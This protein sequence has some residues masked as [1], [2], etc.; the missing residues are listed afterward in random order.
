MPIIIHN[1]GMSNKL[2]EIEIKKTYIKELARIILNLYECIIF[3]SR[4]N[5][6]LHFNLISSNQSNSA[7]NGCALSSVLCWNCDKMGLKQQNCLQSR[8][9][10]CFGLNNELKPNSFCKKIEAK[11]DSIAVG[12]LDA[13]YSTSAASTETQ[14]LLQHHSQQTQH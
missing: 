3:N 2:Q 10:F 9:K 11:T 12:K 1:Y 6:R 13:G 5:S 4:N 14:Q 7:N 8:V